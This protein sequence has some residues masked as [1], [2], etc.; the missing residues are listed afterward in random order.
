MKQMHWAKQAYLCSI[1]AYPLGYLFVHAVR[2]DL[3]F[4]KLYVNRLEQQPPDHLSELFESELLKAKMKRS[5]NAKLALTDELEPKTYGSFLIKPGAEIQ[6]PIRMAFRDVEGARELGKSMELDMGIPSRRKVDMNT[7][8][9]D[10]MV[11]RMIL[12]PA[13]K[14][15]AIQREIVRAQSGTKLVA[16]PMIWCGVTTLGYQFVKFMTPILGPIPASLICLAAAVEAF[17]TIN[18][19]YRANLEKQIDREVLE[20]DPSYATGAR[21]YLKTSMR[22]GRFLR[23]KMGEAGESVF[24]EIGDC[25]KTDAKYSARLTEI[26]HY[27][28]EK[29]GHT[30]QSRRKRVKQQSVHIDYSDIDD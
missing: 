18:N 4:T 23:K 24:S 22:L 21:E 7:H 10:E 6:L 19:H 20:L 1:A 26:D 27:L 29:E 30:T 13:A 16:P 12:S 3:K 14:Q 15:F 11:T 5:F 25:L 9:A 8:L 2:D 17:W 28:R